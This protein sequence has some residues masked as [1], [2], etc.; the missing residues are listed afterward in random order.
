M[1]A[2]TYFVS[3]HLDL[4]QE[5]FDEHYKTRLMAAVY[6]GAMFVVGDARGCD[7]MAQKFLQGIGALMA[8]PVIVFHMLERPRN[9]PCLYEARGG[10]K[11]D[12]ERDAAMTS[13][14][15]AD[16]AWV[17]PGR[18]TS[19]TAK[20]LK[21]RSSDSPRVIALRKALADVA[22]WLREEGVMHG[23]GFFP[24]GD[25][26]DF[27]PDSEGTK[28]E[29]LEAWKVAC[30]AWDE[31]EER[32]E[33]PDPMSPACQAT[34]KGGFITFGKFGLGTYTIEHEDTIKVADE[35]DAALKEFDN[36]K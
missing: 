6:E 13:A 11:T 7:V 16:I 26:K 9:N 23:Y 35:C 4:T 36:G 22:A 21:R 1:K 20:N 18:E 28:P 12:E 31:A 2:K 33:V 14:S 5:E 8:G 3:G 17:R 15:D 10:F 25:P 34:G 32:G 19:G 27:T 30:K 29:E 24:G